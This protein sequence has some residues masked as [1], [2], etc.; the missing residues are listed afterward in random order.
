MFRESS[1]WVARITEIYV[2]IL[3]WERFNPRKDVK[4]SSWFRFEHSWFENPDFFDFTHTEKLIWVY[5]LSLASKKNASEIIIYSSHALKIAD[6][7]IEDLLSALQKLNKIKAI[8]FRYVTSPI[9]GRTRTIGSGTYTNGSVTDTCSTNETRRDE[10]RRDD[11]VNEIRA[12]ARPLL[13]P[14]VEVWN[15]VSS[16][17]LSKV[18]SMNPT[19]SRYRSAIARWREKP[20]REFWVQVIQRLNASSF[21]CGKNDRGWKAD[22]EF[23]CRPDAAE[24]ILEGKYDDNK[25]QVISSNYFD[26]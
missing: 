17:S 26:F 11:H 1:F 2:T 14:L 15:Q 19:S 20:D 25:V 9:R 18:R 5:I 12:I 13:P 21:C 8:V 4:Q 6:F 22:I 10:T 7:S 3:N 23:I 24:K 16:Q